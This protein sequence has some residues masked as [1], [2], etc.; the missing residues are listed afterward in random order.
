MVLLKVAQP[1]LIGVDGEQPRIRN[2]LDAAR[3]AAAIGPRAIDQI[4][5]RVILLAEHDLVA[6]RDFAKWRIGIDELSPIDRLDPGHEGFG[7]IFEEARVRVS[8]RSLG[9]EKE[10]RLGQPGAHTVQRD[11]RCVGEVLD[12]HQPIEQRPVIEIGGWLKY[13][14]TGWTRPDVG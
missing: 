5:Q 14:V 9:V 8:P 3:A 11:R 1:H 6:G 10:L 2:T 4:A 13:S 7:R 12:I